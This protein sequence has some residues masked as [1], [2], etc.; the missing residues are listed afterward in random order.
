MIGVQRYVVGFMLAPD[1]QR[2]LL[3][4]KLRPKWQEGRL[5][6]IGGKVEEGENCLD[7][8]EREFREE[9]GLSR[10]DYHPDGW[11]IFCNLGFGDLARPGSLGELYC[12]WTIGDLEKAVSVTDE[13]VEIVD[14]SS[15][16]NREDMI[17]NVRWLTEMARSFQFGERVNYFDMQ[18]RYFWQ[19]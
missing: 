13:Q 5:N 18:E 9:A 1:L 2:V 4:R 6:G 11:K 8:M 10:E 19:D 17:P 15:L 16:S 14:V 7:A 3:I 12:Y